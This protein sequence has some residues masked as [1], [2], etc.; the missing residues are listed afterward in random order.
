M[1]KLQ[2]A[3]GKVNRTG[4]Q[5][6]VEG[7]FDGLMQ[8]MVCGVSIKVLDTLPNSTTTCINDIGNLKRILSCIKAFQTTGLNIF[9]NC[10]G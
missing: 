2:A 4:N 6:I 9:S 3:L 1:F 8:V 7:L 5:D 10:L